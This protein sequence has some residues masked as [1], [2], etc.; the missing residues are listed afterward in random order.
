MSELT[1][2][3]HCGGRTYEHQPDCTVHPESYC[4]RCGG[5]N[6]AWS[7]PSPLWNMV[8]RGDDINGSEMF[9]G[10]VCPTCFMVLAQDAGVAHL[11]YLTAE[12]LVPLTLITP[13]GRVWDD[14]VGM[15]IEP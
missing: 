11:W 6:R 9:D 3:S 5:P 10:I 15:W 1:I 2:C 12:A 8:M 7:T 4:H 14:A 13:S